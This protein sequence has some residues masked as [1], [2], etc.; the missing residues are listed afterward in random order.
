MAFSAFSFVVQV[1]QRHE[2]N[3]VWLSHHCP[4]T[5]NLDHF[6]AEKTDNTLK[7][8]TKLAGDCKKKAEG[9]E[10]KAEGLEKKAEGLEKKAEEFE[11]KA[12]GCE[13]RAACEEKLNAGKSKNPQQH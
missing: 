12:A 5:N 3:P 2:V 7:G 1:A 11:K 8:L 9:L 10:K 13:K 6:N 4:A